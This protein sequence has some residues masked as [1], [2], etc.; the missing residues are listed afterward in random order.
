MQRYPVPPPGGGNCS[1]H[2]GCASTDNGDCQRY[3]GFCNHA[4]AFVPGARITEAFHGFHLEKIVEAPLTASHAMHDISLMPAACLLRKER[5]GDQRPADR[6]HVTVAVCNHFPGQVRVIDPVAGDDRYGYKFLYPASQ[7]AENS[8]GDFGDDLRHLRLM[9]TDV[10]AEGIYTLPLQSYGVFLQICATGAASH[11]FVAVHPDQQRELTAYGRTNRLDDLKAKTDATFKIAAIAILPLIGERRE[12][13]ADQVAG[14]GQYLHRVEAGLL[15][16]P[17]RLGKAVDDLFYFCNFQLVRRFACQTRRDGRWGHRQ[18]APHKHRVVVASGMVQLNRGAGAIIADCGCQTSQPRNVYILVRADITRV[19][20][21]LIDSGIPDRYHPGSTSGALG[22]EVH[23]PVTHR[24]IS[25]HVHMHGRHENAV[26]DL[27]AIDGN[28]LK[29]R[30]DHDSL[31]G[32]TPHF[33][34][35]G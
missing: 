15:D 6:H 10:Y 32:V 20:G 18:L 5:I 11:E 28:R 22:V 3:V 24:I 8:P 29:K 33:H 27:H 4:R 31:Q 16:P 35:G 17:C 2:S 30:I 9:P 7:I 12:K 23:Q 26:P 14:S 1:T 25:G 34:T 19:S 21:A 13:F